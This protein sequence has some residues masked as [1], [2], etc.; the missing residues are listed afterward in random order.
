MTPGVRS[1]RWV[2]CRGAA[3]GADGFMGFSVCALREVMFAALLRA[4]FVFGEAGPG[5]VG[6][7]GIV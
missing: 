1:A 5:P 7:S 2:Q 3:C 4:V 6:R